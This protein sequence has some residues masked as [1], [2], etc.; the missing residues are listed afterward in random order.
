MFE[1]CITDEQREKK[2]GSDFTEDEKL[3]RAASLKKRA[4]NASPILKRSLKKRN[5]RRRS[6]S[7]VSSI[8]IDDVRDTEELQ[9]VDQFRQALILDELLPEKFDDYHTMLRSTSSILE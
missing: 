3:K 6:G 4:I 1:G 8:S 5:A 2:L 7:R 9:V